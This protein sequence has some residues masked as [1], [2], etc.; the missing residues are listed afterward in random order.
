MKVELLVNLKT[1]IGLLEKGTVFSDPL[2]ADVWDEINLERTTVKILIDTRG[3]S[4]EVVINETPPS[5]LPEPEPVVILKK[6]RGRQ[7]K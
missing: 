6:K 2:P 5:P 7:P 4:Q 3:K 1:S